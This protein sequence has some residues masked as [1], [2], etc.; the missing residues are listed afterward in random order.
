MEQLTDKRKGGALFRVARLKKDPIVLTRLDIVD[1]YMLHHIMLYSSIAR[2]CALVLKL[3]FI[4]KNRNE[5]LSRMLTV[6]V[7]PHRKKQNKTKKILSES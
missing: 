1:S 4:Q 7:P 6:A 3:V 5:F 2:F